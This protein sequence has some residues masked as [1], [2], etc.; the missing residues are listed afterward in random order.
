MFLIGLTLTCIFIKALSSEVFLPIESLK[1]NKLWV[2]WV[3]GGKSLSIWDNIAQI[4]Y[5]KSHPSLPENETHPYACETRWAV[6]DLIQGSSSEREWVMI[7]IGD[8]PFCGSDCDQTLFALE[9]IE[10]NNVNLLSFDTKNTIFKSWLEELHQNHTSKPTLNISAIKQSSLKILYTYRYN[11]SVTPAR[12]EFFGKGGGPL[13]YGG[14]IYVEETI[15]ENTVAPLELFYDSQGTLTTPYVTPIIYHEKKVEE[16]VSIV[17]S[18][19]VNE[20]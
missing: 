15:Y 7:E 16:I 9:S 3:T 1:G 18:S 14:T 19:L 5:E 17:E 11:A 10:E 4:E 2:N 13:S 20:A 8:S 6:S 12:N